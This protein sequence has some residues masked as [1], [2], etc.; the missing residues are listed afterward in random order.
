MTYEQMEANRWGEE[1]AVRERERTM[2]C[3]QCGQGIEGETVDQ[4]C[5]RCHRFRI[6]KEVIVQTLATN[7]LDV[8]S[9][10]GEQYLQD[11]G[12]YVSVEVYVPYRKG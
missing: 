11:H 10:T 9:Y 4:L 7:G 5:D 1:D 3:K 2:R 6:A 8:I 12:T